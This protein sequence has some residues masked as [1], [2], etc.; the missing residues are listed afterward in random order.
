MNKENLIKL[1][2]DYKKNKIDIEQALEVIKNYFYFDL[3]HTKID[4][5][6]ELRKGYPEVIFCA[7]KTPTQVKEIV[8]KMLENKVNI[9]ATRAN[10]EVYEA[11][12]EVCDYA[13]YHKEARIIT[14]KNNEIKETETYIAIVSAGTS[15]I[16]IA[17][18]AAITAKFFGNKIERIY[19]VGVAGIHR[20]YDN[21]PKIRDAKVIIVVAGMEGALPSI[22][23]GLV[24]KPVIAV[25]TSIGYGAAFNGLAALLGMLT[26]CASGVAV[27]NIDNGFGAAY[28][29]SMINKL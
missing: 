20:L 29:A 1:F 13:E 6:R 19:D 24:D 23:G 26:S 21:L 7:G 15:D 28:F 4:F 3:G 14:I 25:P 16:P 12:R 5:H 27:V 8:F 11:V 17:E 9:L 10:V 22:V 2:E 18:E